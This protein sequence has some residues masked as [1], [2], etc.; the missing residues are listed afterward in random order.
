MS[1]III[2]SA[3]LFFLLGLDLL[4]KGRSLKKKSLIGGGTLLL[5]YVFVVAVFQ[6]CDLLAATA[7]IM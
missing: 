6:A 5:V 1:G 7:Y 3:I 2:I 4:R